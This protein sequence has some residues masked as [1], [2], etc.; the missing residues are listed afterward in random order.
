MSELPRLD[1]LVRSAN[2]TADNGNGILERNPFNRRIQKQAHEG[3]RLFLFYLFVSEPACATH[4]Q[5]CTRRVSD[6]HVPPIPQH[7]PYI[8][9][10]V[11][12]W[13]LAGQQVTRHR[14]MSHAKK[15]I[16]HH[17]GKFTGYKHFHRPPPHH[18]ASASSA[19][20]RANTRAMLP[21]VAITAHALP[22][23]RCAGLRPTRRRL[24]R[25][26]RQCA[27]AVQAGR[28]PSRR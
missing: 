10:I 25:G 12:P 6:H 3:Q 22:E 7:I 26:R 14:I 11:R 16:T 2:P 1:Y 4:G 5:M 24:L 19:S 15:G 23:C 21:R 9:L 27:Q 8:A 13:I 28:Q 20:Q 18:W 17:A